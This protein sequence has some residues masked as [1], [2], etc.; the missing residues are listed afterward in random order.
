M[1][2]GALLASLA[3]VL[4][5]APVAGADHVYAHR[6]V[7]EG[8]LLGSD[9]APL[10]NRTVEFFSVGDEFPE[11]CVGGS[12]P[13]TD[14]NGDFR[15]C[16]HKHELDPRTQVG[17][18]AGNASATKAMDTAFRKS[19]VILTEPH[20][21]GLA[22]EGWNASHLLA[23]RVWRSGPQVVEGVRVYGDVLAGVP[24]NVTVR[25]ALDTLA[26]FQA[27]TDRFGDFAVPFEVDPALPAEDVL[28]EVEAMGQRQTRGLDAFSHRLTVGFMLPSE[29]LPRQDEV[30]VAFPRPERA[31]LPGESTGRV[32]VGLVAVMGLAALG[33]VLLARRQTR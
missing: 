10:A 30:D 7:L 17:A 9:G 23:G 25:V 2:R 26:T 27:E 1:R 4:L 12:Q 20:E 22:P 19:V 5:L 18:R 21:T 15:F 3:L 8:R 11:H 31:P 29:T 24:V 6:F 13:V 32:G 16:F 14:E 33:A 28:V